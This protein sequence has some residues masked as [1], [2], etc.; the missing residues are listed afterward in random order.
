MA[1]R[2][3]VLLEGYLGADPVVRYTAGNTKVANVRMATS[4]SYKDNKGEWQ[5]HTSWHALVFYDYNADAAETYKKGENIHIEGHIQDREFAP[6]GES[7]ARTVKEIIVERSHVIE[8]SR[9]SRDDDDAGQGEPPGDGDEGGG[10]D[11]PT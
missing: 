3:F 5:K 11:W 6:K 8:R 1:N 10:D 7:K 4:Y 2:N 9:V